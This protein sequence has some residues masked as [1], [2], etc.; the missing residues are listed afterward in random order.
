MTS[1][2][3]VSADEELAIRVVRRV[4]PSV[5]KAACRVIRFLL[6][7]AVPLAITAW[8]QEAFDLWQHFTA[9]VGGAPKR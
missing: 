5:R 9:T 6:T 8:K 1:D 2:F 4:G 3:Q 7:V